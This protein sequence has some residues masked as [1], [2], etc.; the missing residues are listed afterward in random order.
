MVDKKIA[1]VASEPVATAVGSNRRQRRLVSRAIT[2]DGC[3]FIRRQACA[4]EPPDANIV[5]NGS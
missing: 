1:K 3:F 4:S 5:G 2:N